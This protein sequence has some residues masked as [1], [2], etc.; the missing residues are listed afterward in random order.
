MAAFGLLALSL[1]LASWRALSNVVVASACLSGLAALAGGRIERALWTRVA[2]GLVLALALVWLGALLS[3]EVSGKEA[4]QAT[5]RFIAIALFAFAWREGL[6]TIGGA[7]IMSG[8]FAAGAVS[9]ALSLVLHGLHAPGLGARLELL[10]RPLNPIPGAAAAAAAGLAGVA[11]WRAGLIVGRARIAAGVALAVILIAMALTQSRGPALGVTGALVALLLTARRR[12][13]ASAWL[14]GLGFLSAPGVIV[15]LEG[16]F[17][18]AFCQSEVFLCRR[19]ARLELWRAAADQIFAHP[20]FGM[21]VDFKLG[22]GWF[23]NPQNAALGA[24]LYFGLPFLL[25]C[26]AGALFL[27]RRMARA[28]PPAALD[29]APAGARATLDWALACLVLSGFYYAFEP[30]PFAF[31]NAHWIFF[32]APVATILTLG[33]GA[34]VTERG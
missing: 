8:L 30:N 3:P 4:R 19:S 1:Y 17:R 23:N 29:A 20:W 33:A 21:G 7:R 32:W 22:E 28:A 18:S 15:F 34:R 27:L 25:I 2:L 26:A 5:G 6:R 16:P 9:C 13:R 24:A 12:G 14:A 11:L 31:Y 10:G